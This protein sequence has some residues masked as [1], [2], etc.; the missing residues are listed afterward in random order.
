MVDDRVVDIVKRVGLEGLYRTPCREIDHNLI[1]TFVE[2]WRPETHTFHPHGETT[3]TLQDVEVILGIPIDGEAVVGTTDKIWTTECRTMLGINPTGTTLK[4]QRILIKKLLYKIDQGLPDDA[5]EV[6]V[7]QYARCYI[8]ALLADTIFADKFGDRVHMMWLQMLSDLCNPPQYSWGSACLAWLYRELCKATD[9]GT[10]QI[11]GAL[12]LVQY[13][14][15]FK[16][17]F[18]CP[19]KN[20]P[21]DDAYSPPF[22]PSPLSIK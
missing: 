4:G 3:I 10:S 20:L 7:R 15:W 8:L 14:A 5:T 2:R 13:W 21:P 6:D 9:R 17:P 18:L 19:R 1:T 22:A 16:F 11:G 12:L